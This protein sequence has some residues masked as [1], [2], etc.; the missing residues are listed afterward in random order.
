MDACSKHTGVCLSMV[1]ITKGWMSSDGGSYT[2]IAPLVKT[3]RFLQVSLSF[4]SSPPTDLSAAGDQIR[5]A[6]FTSHSHGRWLAC[7]FQ[8]PAQSHTRAT[9]TIALLHYCSW[10]FSVL[11]RNL[12]C[13]L[14]NFVLSF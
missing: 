4:R 7:C 9:A 5:L 3:Q 8:T 1:T 10:I 12:C 2:R 11:T 13:F 14:Q 6:A